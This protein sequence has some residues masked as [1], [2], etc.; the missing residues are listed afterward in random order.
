[1]EDGQRNDVSK[2]FAGIDSAGLLDLVAAWYVKATRYINCNT[3]VRCAFVSTNSITQGEQVAVLWSWMLSNG[4]YIQ[5]AHRTFCWSNEGKGVAAVHCVIIGFGKSNNLAKRIYDYA[6]INGE[7]L[8]RK[9]SNINPY[10]ADAANVVLT[11]RSK[12]ICNAPEI[13]IGNKPI[14]GGLYLFTT[15]ERDAF[16]AKEPKSAVLFRRWLGA[17]EFLNG[18]ERWCLLVG[19]REPAELRSMPLVMERINAVRELRLAS[20][21]APTIKLAATPTRF[22]V[23]FMPAAPYMVIPEVSSERRDYIPLGYLL[24]D[25]LASNKL[26]LLPNAAL[27]QFG[28][29]HSSMHMAWTRYTCGRLESRYQYSINIV[30]NN[31]PWPQDFGDKVK[32]T[33]EV[34]AQAIIDARKLHPNATLADL[35]DPLTMPPELC[36]AHEANN[37]AVDKAY[38]YKG[39]NEDAS[40]V[41][42]LFKLYEEI[43][44]LLVTSVSKKKR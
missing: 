40:R 2:V 13:G 39:G 6:D 32:A 36:K 22:H 10:L 17:D 42:F 8:V 23:E 21:S 4:M 26:R 31:F 35:Y 19:G 12:S 25:T 41:A 29:L 27:W 16:I 20:K 38:G 37:R 15:E 34:A 1:M 3:S 43:T 18:Y 44:S 9:V 33:I 30:Y 24:P 7:P 28:I 14:D 5:F 11:R